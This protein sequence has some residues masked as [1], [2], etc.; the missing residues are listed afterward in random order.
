M[1]ELGRRCGVTRESSRW[2]EGG[3]D[4]ILG[5]HKEVLDAGTTTGCMH[6]G[7]GV[8]CHLCEHAQK[9]GQLGL[10]MEAE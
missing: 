3:E 4:R 10:T 7:A 1:F 9:A 6:D 8:V 5:L 2:Q